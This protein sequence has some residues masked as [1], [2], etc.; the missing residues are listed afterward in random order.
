MRTL[1]RNKRE[2]YY[3]LY[4]NHVAVT[5]ENGFETGE[6]AAGYETPVSMRANISPARGTSDIEQFGTNLLY[7]KMIVTSDMNCPIDEH[8][9]LWVDDTNTSHPY[10]Y[11]VASVA[12]SINSITYAIAKVKTSNENP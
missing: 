11:I 8:S 1:D 5:D 9:I 12:K 6:Y 4:S 7:D 2:F 3:A 10:D